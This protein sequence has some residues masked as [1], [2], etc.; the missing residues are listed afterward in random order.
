VEGLWH[1]WRPHRI[2]SSSSSPPTPPSTLCKASE[3]EEEAGREDDEP[4]KVQFKIL[5]KKK[6]KNKKEMS[7]GCSKLLE[8]FFSRMPRFY[9]PKQERF[10][11]MQWHLAVSHGNQ[12]IKVLQRSLPRHEH[13]T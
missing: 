1:D 4:I 2:R 6:K 8:D 3:A 10:K 9:L 5:K 7:G 12:V 11:T 13:L